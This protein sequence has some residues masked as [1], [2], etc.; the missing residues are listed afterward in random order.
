MSTKPTPKPPA[1]THK[2]Q[3]T[4]LVGA[5]ALVAAVIVGVVVA[6]R[7]GASRDENRGRSNENHSQEPPTH[8]P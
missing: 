4:Y 2:R 7:T 3:T 5:A 6:D 8:Q 1:E